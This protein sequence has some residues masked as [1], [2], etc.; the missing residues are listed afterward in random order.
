ML[1]LRGLVSLVPA[2]R[3][4]LT[5]LYAESWALFFFLAKK[6]PKELSAYLDDLSARKQMGEANHTP[7]WSLFERHFK[8]YPIAVAH[9]CDV[10]PVSRPVGVQDCTDLDR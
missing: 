8:F 3:V 4:N 7:E 5:D 1:G 2:E 10:D 6:H 9:D